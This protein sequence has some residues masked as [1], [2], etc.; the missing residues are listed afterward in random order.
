MAVEVRPVLPHEHA[1]AGGV[2]RAAF[3]ALYG[4]EGHDEYLETAADVAG[5]AGRTTVLVAVEGDRILG[6]ITLE[7][8]SK[9]NPEGRLE[10]GEA[11]LRLLGVAP[12]AQG[13]GV[14]RMLMEAAAIHARAAGKHRLTLG[15][16]PEMAAARHLYD[17]LW[18]RG[19]GRVEFA[20]GRWAVTYELPLDKPAPA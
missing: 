20:P 18:Y 19:G 15:T 1:Q 14:G 13:R 2:T 8:E 5:R 6:S 11:H 3:R 7:L 9:V 4:D 16:M 10:P 12:E 17:T